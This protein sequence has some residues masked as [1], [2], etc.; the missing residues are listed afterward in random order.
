MRLLTF[1]VTFNLQKMKKEELY[2]ELKTKHP[3]WSDLQIWTQVSIM[4]QDDVISQLGPNA[5]PTV[6]IMR[7]VLEK[8]K[9][10]LFDVLPDIF[11]KVVGFFNELI[12]SLP[13]WAKNGIMYA[14]KLATHYFARNL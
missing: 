1:L 12:D 5:N 11:A 8:A 9:I 7:V 10:W 3:E 6:E 13:E 4:M 14:L 2:R